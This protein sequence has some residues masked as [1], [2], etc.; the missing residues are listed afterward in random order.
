MK[1]SSSPPSIPSSPDPKTFI[2]LW[3]NLE[4]NGGRN[5]SL[6]T[7]EMPTA[8]HA[9]ATKSQQQSLAAALVVSSSSQG[10]SSL[11]SDSEISPASSPSSAPY[12]TTI[13]TTANTGEITAS[14]ALTTTHVAASTVRNSASPS[15]FFGAMDLAEK[16]SENELSTT[17]SPS[18]LNSSATTATVSTTSP[19]PGRGGAPRNNSS[20]RLIFSSPLR[21]SSRRRKQPLKQPVRALSSAK[22]TESKGI[23]F[24]FPL[25]PGSPFNVICREYADMDQSKTN[26]ARTLSLRGLA[27]GAATGRRVRAAAATAARVR[28]R[29]T[30]NATYE[31]EDTESESE[32]EEEVPQPRPV[33]PRS[34]LVY[35][36]TPQELLA[37]VTKTS[38]VG[39]RQKSCACC[40]CTSTPLWRDI[41][42]ELPLCNACGIRWKKYG[43][44]CDQC[45]YVPCKQERDSPNCKRCGSILS[46]ASRRGSRPSS[47]NATAPR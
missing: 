35:T 12:V 8:Q 46:A 9:T 31:S 4:A 1:G 14:T 21:G 44:V 36:P 3:K 38:A 16:Q 25:T 41:G 34:P 11:S 42:K 26:L 19:L 47:S 45:Q 17:A 20:K 43:I 10:S 15:V 28:S 30:A 32:P 7:T 22:D 40:G 2:S 18:Y 23:A 27:G 39:G 13:T 29:A 37:P 6:T 24:R 33:T 5:Q